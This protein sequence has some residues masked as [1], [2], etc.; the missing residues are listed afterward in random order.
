MFALADPNILPNEVA[1][2]DDPN[3]L[4]TLFVEWR[5]ERSEPYITVL[6]ENWLRTDR[7]RDYPKTIDGVLY[8]TWTAPYSWASDL[9]HD[10][11][12]DMQDFGIVAKFYT[13]GIEY[14]PPV[15]APSRLELLAMFAEMIF[16][17]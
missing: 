14:V 9:N 11:A 3:V 13:G 10:N 8:A 17:E 16:M 4:P 7:Q 12:I 15:P 5:E 1:W 2:L 6:V